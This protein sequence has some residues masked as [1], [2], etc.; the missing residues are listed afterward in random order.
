MVT[1]LVVAA[2]VT[3]EFISFLNAVGIYEAYEHEGSFL[4]WQV[5]NTDPAYLPIN[6]TSTAIKVGCLH[7]NHQNL[8]C[9]SQD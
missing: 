4:S 3:L 5:N 9:L 1:K 8:R 6:L 7:L 2:I